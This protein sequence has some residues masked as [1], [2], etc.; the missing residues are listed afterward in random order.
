MNLILNISFQGKVVEHSIEDGIISSN[1]SLVLQ[2]ISKV[3]AGNYSCTAY[4]SE[5]NGMSNAVTLTIKCKIKNRHKFQFGQE[6]DIHQYRLY[7]VILRSN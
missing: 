6:Y 5:G 2:S 7:T 1:Q 3:S 4:N